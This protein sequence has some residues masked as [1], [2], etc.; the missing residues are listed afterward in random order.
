MK[1]L[2]LSA[3]LG[4]RLRPLTLLLPKPLIPV[5]NRPLITYALEWLASQG[6]DEVGINLH[7]LPHLVPQTLGDG[8]KWGLRLQYS[9]EPEIL[10]TGGGIAKLAGGFLNKETLLVVNC[11]ILFQL[12]LSKA[13][14]FHRERR[15]KV[16]IGLV[17]R[18]L[19]PGGKKPSLVSID[20]AGRVLRIGPPIINSSNSQQPG[21]P[22]SGFVFSGIHIIE[23]DIIERIAVDRYSCIVSDTYMRLIREN[24]PI[25][26]YPYLGDQRPEV[27]NS[28]DHS[29]Q[30]QTASGYWRELGTPE[31]YWE[32]QREILAGKTPFQSRPPVSVSGLWIDPEARISP[33]AQ[34]ISPVVIGRYSVV[35]EGA[36]VGPY[37]IIGKGCR[38]GRGA[39]LGEC[40]LW[41]GVRVDPQSRITQAILAGRGKLYSVKMDVA[42]QRETIC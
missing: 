15:A 27:R 10:G 20:N 28:K 25:Y 40:L 6:V 34:I 24:G 14:A 1:A 11:D 13:L 30:E 12:D 17:D 19:L 39:R 9:F 26:G 37:A 33:Q 7:H 36:R 29:H 22:S 18:K 16:T 38:I 3:G 35:E 8:S 5:V 32:V 41:D 21:D 31:R 23:P 2:I 42:K 4:T